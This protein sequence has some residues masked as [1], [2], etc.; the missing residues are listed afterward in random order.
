MSNQDY[1]KHERLNNIRHTLAHLTAAAVRELWPGSKNAIGPAIED[2]FYQDFE[3]AGTITKQDLPKI[4]KKIRQLIPRWT[5]FEKKEVSKEEALKA[6]AWNKYKTELIEEFAKEGKKLTFHNSPGFIDLCKGGHVEHPSKEIKPDAF[7]LTKLAG[8]YWRGDEKNKMLTRIYG[9][10]FESKE[11]LEHH[12]AMLAE[13]E[14]R[15]HKVLG[16]KL[17]LFMF[18]LT[19][20]GAPYWLPKGMVLINQLIEFWRKEHSKRGYQEISA[21]LV[22]KKE[23]WETSGHWQHY[24]ENMFVANMGENEI[25]GIKAMNCPNAMLVFGS[26]LRSYRD[27]PLRL[28]DTDILHRYELAGTL[29]GLFRVRA[30]RQDDSHN[31]ITEDMVESEYKEIFKIVKLFYGVFKLRYEFRLGTRPKDFLGEIDVWNR[32]EATLKKILDQSKIK[33]TVA[34]GDG[35][36]YGPK[37]DILMNDALG[38]EWQ[39]GTVQLDFQQPK[40]FGLEYI[41]NDGSRKTPVCVHRVIYGSIERFIGILIEHYSGAFPLWLSPV[42]VSVLSISKKHNAYAKKI[43]KMLSDMCYGLRVELDDRDESVGKKI[44]EATMQKIPYQIIVG[45]KEMKAKKIAV[46]TREGKDLGVMSLKKFVER[47]VMEIEKKK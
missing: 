22:N 4:E 20:P 7:K 30:F 39:M 9:V 35:A 36:F 47:L 33:Y 3:V 32:A 41:E 28:S 27:L 18:H 23:L 12:L 44:R 16:P 37:V 15:D 34:E 29:N 5:H 13:A 14:K 31:F 21:P 26:R 43:V 19:S 6:F 2:G 45:D 25:Y 17:D 1:L 11:E 42:Q 46:R 8:A 38:R 40:R 10:A 24:H